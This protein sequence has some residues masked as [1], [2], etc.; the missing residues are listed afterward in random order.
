MEK[1]GIAWSG[2][3]TNGNMLKTHAH[4]LNANALLFRSLRRSSAEIDNRGDA[5]LFQFGKIAET[6]LRAAVKMLVDLSS[7]VNTCELKF[8]S[9]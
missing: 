3:S 9:R 4:G 7:V 5:E 2:K 1:V 6:G 8:F